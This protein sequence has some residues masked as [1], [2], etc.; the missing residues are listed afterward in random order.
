V[1][2]AIGTLFASV[3]TTCGGMH[4]ANNFNSWNADG[5]MGTI[6][7]DRWIIMGLII[8]FIAIVLAA[9]IFIF[10][11]ASRIWERAVAAAN[12]IDIERIRVSGTPDK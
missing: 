7:P 11:I 5:T 1:L 6:S 3:G 8:V 10:W 4:L 12:A 9:S 2:T